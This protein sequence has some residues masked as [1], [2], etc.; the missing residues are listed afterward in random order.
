MTSVVIADLDGRPATHPLTGR[1]ARHL[2]QTGVGVTVY[3]R[4]GTDPRGRMGV[5]RAVRRA[6]GTG[7][8]RPILVLFGHEP[9]QRR[10]MWGLAL[11]GLLPRV[12]LVVHAPAARTPYDPQ[13]AELFSRAEVV[14]TDSQAGAQAVHRCCTD[15]DEPPPRAVVTPPVFPS[16][17]SLAAPAPIDRRAL[18]RARLGVDD[19]GL[20]VGCWTDEEVEVGLLTMEVFSQ[21]SQGHYSRCTRCGH[22]TPWPTDEHLESVP[23]A[24]CGRCG[25]HS[26]TP[27]RVRDDTRLLL[28]SGP[29]NGD[30]EWV[31]QAVGE[32]RG[33]EDRIIYQDPGSADD[34]SRLWGCV[35]LHLQPHLLADVP[36]SISASCVLGVPVV[37]TRYGALEEWLE[38]AAWLVPPRMVLDHSAGPRTALMDPGGALTALCHL[39][40]DR[41]A[42]RRTAADMRALADA[43]QAGAVLDRWIELLAVPVTT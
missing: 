3:D 5:A 24:Q 7:D 20:V 1:L 4:A 12:R 43:H 13:L 29:S 42:R 37:A 39:A 28:M 36:A 10:E 15:A 18:R 11:S 40:D 21:F 16:P 32:W 31:P 30:G 6:F 8:S 9:T 38:D 19:D 14:V 26:G 25:S 33:I 22:L 34:V 27:G 35:D 41:A 23:V 2:R 17:S